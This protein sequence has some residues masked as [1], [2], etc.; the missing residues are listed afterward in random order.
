[1]GNLIEQFVDCVDCHDE[2]LS[3][4]VG[5]EYDSEFFSALRAYP[6]KM[7][8]VWYIVMN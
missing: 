1:M 4:G 2:E 7:N 6:L 3:F 8:T 5:G